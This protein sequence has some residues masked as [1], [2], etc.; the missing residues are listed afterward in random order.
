MA[1][2][3]Q[4]VISTAKVEELGENISA[5]NSKL[6]DLVAAMQKA[7]ALYGEGQAHATS[8]NTCMEKMRKIQ[9]KSRV[10]TKLDCLMAEIAKCMPILFTEAPTSELT[11]AQ[12]DSLCKSILTILRA[13]TGAPC[14]TGVR[15]YVHFCIRELR[16]N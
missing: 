13:R 1:K 4:H 8:I 16:Q 5:D 11:V 12:R 2:Y 6:H 14:R 15:C 10:K 3:F 9:A 7:M